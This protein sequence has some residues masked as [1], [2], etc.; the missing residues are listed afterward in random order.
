MNHQNGKAFPKALVQLARKIPK[1]Y[2]DGGLPLNVLDL[3]WCAKSLSSKFGFSK[4]FIARQLDLPVKTVGHL[5]SAWDCTDERI[6]SALNMPIKEV[7]KLR[8]EP[9]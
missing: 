5:Q 6:A 3:I 4:E 1:R 7:K 8:E 9:K 2:P